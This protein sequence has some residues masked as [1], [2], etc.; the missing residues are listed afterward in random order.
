M[1]VDESR[2]HEQARPWGPRLFERRDDST[3]DSD[4]EDVIEASGSEGTTYTLTFTAKTWARIQAVLAARQRHP[5]TRNQRVLGQVHGHSFLP[6]NSGETCDGCPSQG[7]CQLSTA[8][9]SEEDRGWCRSVFPREPWQLSHVFGLT[10]RREPINAFYGQRST[11][12]ERRGY[13]V[14]DETLSGP[15]S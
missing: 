6:Y 4:V 10:P 13:Y 2:R 7:K 11:L 15:S 3:L 5:A 1:R 12:L 9:L 8:F 14:L